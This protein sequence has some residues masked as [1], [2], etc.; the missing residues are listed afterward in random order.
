MAEQAPKPGDKQR[1]IL[2]LILVIVA[3]MPAVLWLALLVAERDELGGG[4]GSPVEIA[5]T[6]LVVSL[7]V[8]LGVVAFKLSRVLEYI[9]PEQIDF[10]AMSDSFSDIGGRLAAYLDRPPPRPFEAAC[11]TP[12]WNGLF[13][14]AARLAIALL[15]PLMLIMLALLSYM[16][17]GAT[18]A[19]RIIDR[20]PVSTTLATVTDV[21]EKHDRNGGRYFEARYRFK[22]VAGTTYLHSMSFADHTALRPGD[23]APVEYI[24]RDPSLNRLEGMRTTPIDPN[25]ILL[26][27]GAITLV[28]LPSFGV[29]V[30][31]RR[32]FARVLLTE[33][34][35]VD[36]AI[37]SLRRGGRGAVFRKVEYRFRGLVERK[38]LAVPA[39][40]SLYATLHNRR[41]RH[42]TIKVLAHPE[43]F[44]SVY[45][46]EPILAA[47]R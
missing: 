41:Q 25:A 13:P 24:A 17:L 30:W 44:G 5:A 3:M 33:G 38:R 4:W 6:L 11:L 9:D 36:A 26:P 1:Y 8:V 21:K 31:W 23:L 2:G 27:A 10:P 20:G 40:P 37:E 42:Q 35:L 28:F 29:Y 43:R 15:L 45:L 14:P 22:P 34:V 12:I 32:R 39:D 18:K 47:A 46:I 16:I 19:D 7:V